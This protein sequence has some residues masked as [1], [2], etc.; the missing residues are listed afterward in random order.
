MENGDLQA[1]VEKMISYEPSYAKLEI[2]W[3]HT[4]TSMWSVTYP[5]TFTQLHIHHG[6][7]ICHK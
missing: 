6:H 1:N 4:S 3:A 5:Y 2:M 7:R